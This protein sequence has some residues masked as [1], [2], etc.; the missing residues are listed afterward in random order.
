MVMNAFL[1]EKAGDAANFEKWFMIADPALLNPY[2]RYMMVEL[3]MGGLAQTKTV[4]QLL[5][6]YDD[7]FL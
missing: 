2:L 6:G 7:Q 5:F 1:Y 3:A 4:K